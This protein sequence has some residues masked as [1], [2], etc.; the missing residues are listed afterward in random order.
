MKKY[1]SIY[2]LIIATAFV[3][4]A[5]L[6]VQFIKL[7]FGS[8]SNTVQA[9][10]YREF[11]TSTSLILLAVL[12]CMLHWLFVAKKRTV[13]ALHT[14]SSWLKSVLVGAA[15]AFIMGCVGFFAL[16]MHSSQQAPELGLFIF[17][18]PII[19][20]VSALVGGVVGLLVATARAV[21][22]AK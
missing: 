8:S 4:G 7:D 13:R 20:F 2:A 10:I 3:L 22:R 21:A 11:L 19:G 17:F 9:P 5:V 16:L 6:Q 15:I 1:L 18:L 14:S 12:G